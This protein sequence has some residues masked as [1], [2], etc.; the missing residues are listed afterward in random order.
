MSTLN[1]TSQSAAEQPVEIVHAIL[2]VG[3]FDRFSKNVYLPTCAGSQVRSKTKLKKPAEAQMRE[4]LDRGLRVYLWVFDSP[5]QTP[6]AVLQFDNPRLLRKRQHTDFQGHSSVDLTSVYCSASLLKGTK[7][8]TL[9]SKEQLAT[10][11]STTEL[12][13]NP[14]TPVLLP[15]SAN[16]YLG[17]QI[18]SLEAYQVRGCQPYEVQQSMMSLQA[19][20]ATENS[21]CHLQGLPDCWPCRLV[22]N[23][24]QAKHAQYQVF[25]K[26]LVLQRGK[27]NVLRQKPLHKHFSLPRKEQ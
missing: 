8:A 14:D 27:G 23:C 25:Q 3:D 2:N 11:C 26:L 15:V 5:Y 10:C 17:T 21:C 12:S 18:A 7:L 20:I 24:F 4:C 1:S 6:H 16:S 19:E 13:A 9:C 22:L